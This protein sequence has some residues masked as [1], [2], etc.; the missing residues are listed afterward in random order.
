MIASGVTDK[1]FQIAKCFRD[2]AGRKDRQ[3]EFTQLDLEMGFVDGCPRHEAGEWRIGG[4]QVRRTIEGLIGSV[5]REAKNEGVLPSGGFRVMT[6]D[7]AMRTFGSDKPD[8]RFGMKIVDLGPY[9]SSSDGE[10]WDC[11]GG[12][13][14]KQTVE[15][16]AFRVP[17]KGKDEVNVT[18]AGHSPQGQKSQ[19][20][21]KAKAPTPS[22]NTAVGFSNKDMAELVKD[23]S[24]SDAATPHLERFKSP[25]SSPHSLANLLLQKSSHLRAHLQRHSIDAQDVD[26][27]KL[28]DGVRVAIEQSAWNNDGKDDADYEEETHLFVSS[29]RDPPVG[30]STA[31]GNLR[32]RLRDAV[33]SKSLATLPTSPHFL[34]VTEFPLFTQSDEEKATLTGRGR[35][36]STHHPFTAPAHTSMREVEDILTRLQNGAEIT[37]L[38]SALENIKG[39]HYDLVLNGLEIGGGSVRIHS[40]ALQRHVFTHILQLSGDEMARFDH[41]LAALDSGCPPHGGI[42]LGF[43]RL[44]TF[45]TRTECKSIRDVIAFPK[46]TGGKDMLFG[47]P[48]GF[49][50][51]KERREVRREWGMEG[52]TI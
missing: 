43:D 38:A 50:D 46:S 17:K 45:L 41:L 22:S 8:V 26:A 36:A 6:Y 44:M 11:E 35:W 47:S 5:W 14:A 2:E 15:I 25:N 39:Q 27:E 42:A 52:D 1:Y 31:L 19:N 32:L 49:E 23:E 34:W 30:A 4:E 29:R 28:A 9:I 37:H 7:E 20:R 21:N 51:E 10:S 16:L 3:P 18:A 24:G 13:G 12:S 40:A 33:V 48:A